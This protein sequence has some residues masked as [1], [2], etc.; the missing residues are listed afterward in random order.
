MPG[1]TGAGFSI[2]VIDSGVDYNH[3]SLGGGWG[4]KVTAGWDFAA[5]DSNPMSD[6]YAHGTGVAGILGAD[7][8]DYKGYHYQGVA[9]GAKIIALRQNNS[10]GVANALKWVIANKSKYNITAVNVTDYAG[11]GNTTIW[12]SI[13]ASIGQLNA[14]GI[15]VSSP[16][17]NSGSKSFSNTDPDLVEVGSVTLGDGISGFTNRGPGLDFLAPGDNVTLPYYDVGSK[18]HIYVDTA[19]GTSWSSPHIA[20]AVALIRQVNPGFSN[21]QVTSILKDSAAW[22][23]DSATGRS[24]PRLS[25]YNAVLLAYQ[26]AGKTPP[27]APPTTTTT[28]PQPPAG[29]V[30]TNPTNIGT[31]TTIQIEDFDSGSSGQTW[32]D[33]TAGNQGGNSYRSNTSVDV[34]TLNDSGSTRG[35]GFVKAGEWLKYTVN[36]Q[37]AGTYNLEFRVSALGTGGQ[38]RLEVDG[39]DV[40][41]ALNV[42]N[43]GSWNTYQTLT[44]SGVSLAAGKHTL[45]LYFVRNGSSGFVANFNQMKFVKAGTTPTPAPTPNPTT[46]PAAIVP[47]VPTTLQVENFDNGTRGGTW[48]DTDT[49]DQ[50]GTNYRPGIGVDVIAI[51]DS[52]STRGVGFVKAGEWLKYTVNVAQAGTYDLEFRIAAQGT[53]GQFRLE[54]DGRDVTGALNVPNTGNWNTYQTVTKTGVSLP[55]GTHSLRLFFSRNGGSGYVGNFNQIRFI[56]KTTAPANPPT[57]TTIPGTWS[58]TPGVGTTIQA[59][60]FTTYY[61]RDTQNRA[62]QYR[63]TGVDI[64]TTTDTGGGYHVGYTQTGEILNYSVN[65][66]RAGT[67]NLETRIASLASGARFHVEIDGRNVTGSLNFGTG[68]WTKW[69]TLK[70][71]GISMAAGRHT[72][73]VFVE[74]SGNQTWAGNLNWIRFS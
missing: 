74:S 66:T 33:S 7:P 23:Y 12:N 31:N 29:V 58:L 49:T 16:S 43:T 53:G 45:R 6:S 13:N 67:F 39:K 8:Y 65:V 41:G 54:L 11:G 1:I 17:G 56:P 19:D 20:G 60:D 34:I 28:D 63:N 68:G 47:S 22:K 50:G 40:T 27:A 71:T 5:N 15:Y 52:G 24:Y 18:R 55:A 10:G 38:F 2:A 69:V 37:S 73:K 21:S 3:P 35:V 44:K 36:V 30:V 51:N 72:V 42:P 48:W 64:E 26:R 9:P 46:I 61:D 70:K 14:M 4:K 62:G 59:E 25:I 32:W 57:N